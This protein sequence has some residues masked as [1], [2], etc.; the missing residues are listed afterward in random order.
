V[1]AAIRFEVRRGLAVAIPLDAD[2]STWINLV[3]ARIEL[4]PIRVK[5]DFSPARLHLAAAAA[6]P[7]GMR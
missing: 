1:H 6:N 5:A 2:P 4:L 7:Y 3:A